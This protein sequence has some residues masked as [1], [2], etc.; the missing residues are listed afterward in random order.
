VTRER[1]IGSRRSAQNTDVVTCT[2]DCHNICTSV[3]SQNFDCVPSPKKK[4]IRGE[5]PNAA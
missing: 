4:R 1:K 2:T 5:N 3:A